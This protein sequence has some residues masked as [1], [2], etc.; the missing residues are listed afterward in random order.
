MTSR[1]TFAFLL[2]IFI[3]A[4]S[5]IRAEEYDLSYTSSFDLLFWRAHEKSLVL[6][7]KTSPVF[8]TDNFTDAK[9]LHPHFNWNVGFRVG[10]AY[11]I[12]C[13]P[14][15]AALDWTF[16]ET[17]IHQKRNTNSSGDDPEGMFPIWA[18]A[19]DIIAG[20]YVSLAELE[21]KLNLNVVD[22]DFNYAFYCG[23]CFV[24]KPHG[25]VRTAW[26]N[27]HAHMVYA[28]GIFLLDII[29][30]GV[31][32]RGADHVHLRNNFWGMGPRI[33]LKPELFLG[34]GF[35]LYGDAAISVLVAIFSI[36]QKEEY[37]SHE[38]FE[39]KKH[40]TRARWVGDLS[41]GI[42]WKTFLCEEQ[43]VLT[44]K[45]GWEYH[46]FFHQL[47]LKGDAFHL[48]SHDRNLDVQGITLGSEI[49][50]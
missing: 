8:F 2:F 28:G 1:T 23:N 7:N 12:P 48:V 41:A 15:Q 36:Q 45:L 27:Q 49:E 30:G 20:D 37:L 5:G 34:N 31:S 4:S 19:P 39:W 50:F 6:T 26:I 10:F 44:L 35:S 9:V 11:A 13:S 18:I 46:I 3:A 14:W 38:R 21:G 22:L 24:I 25:G 16:Y 40:R 33:G 17:T 32:M 43:N 47:E 29:S 42:A